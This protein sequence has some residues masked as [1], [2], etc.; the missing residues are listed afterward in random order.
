MRAFRPLALASVFLLAAFAPPSTGIVSLFNASDYVV[1]HVY[2]SDCGTDEWEDDLLGQYVL[3]PGDELEVELSTGCWD[4]M[5]LVE[6][7]VALDTYSIGI[8][9]GDYVEWTIS[10]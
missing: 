5:A 9:P 10:N 3:E 1:T 4:L 6:G 8:G 7:E 2:A